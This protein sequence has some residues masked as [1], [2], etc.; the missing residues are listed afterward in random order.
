MK[1]G[2]EY[3][4][5]TSRIKANVSSCPKRAFIFPIPYSLCQRAGLEAACRR[6][7]RHPSLP[8]T[9]P[10]WLPRSSPIWVCPPEARPVLR[11]WPSLSFK[12]PDSTR[13]PMY[14]GSAPEPTLPLGPHPPNTPQCVEILGN[15]LRTRAGKVLLAG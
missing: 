6:A 4:L 13:D 2:W 3:F 9:I 12:R 5:D 1:R 11:R 7:L 8:S 10:R 14:F 15:I